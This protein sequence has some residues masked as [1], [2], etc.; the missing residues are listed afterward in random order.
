MRLFSVS[1]HPRLPAAKR[2]AALVCLAL[3]SA[4]V[5]A[6]PVITEFMASNK[7]ILTDEDGDYSDWIE[8]YN[9]DVAAV[10]L[11]NWSLTDSAQKKTKWQ[12]PAITIPAGGYL[13]VFASSKDRSDPAQPLHTNFSLSAD[14]E[15]LG[16]IEPDGTT[17]ATEFSPAFPS[18]END[19]SYGVTQPL[20]PSESPQTGSFSVPTPGARNGNASTLA[21]L[22]T[23]S[24]STPSGFFSGTLTL[25]VSGQ[26]AG[27]KIRYVLAPPS[28]AG[29]EV[30]EPTAESPEYTG[31]IALSSSTLVRA[32]VFS[33]DDT[34]RGPAVSAHY[35]QLSGTGSERVD[36]FSSRLPLIVIDNHGYGAMVKDGIDRPGWIYGFAPSPDGMASF[37]ETSDFAFPI[38]FAVRG[39]SSSGFP[40]KSFKLKTL[41]ALGAKQPLAPFGLPAFNKWQLIG[42]WGFD[43]AFI[44]NAYVYALSNRIG[45]WAA[46]TKLVEVFF[47]NNDDGLNASDYAGIYTLTD[48]I[49]VDPQRVNIADISPSDVTAPGVTGGYILKIDWPDPG[50]Y[51]WTT[52][53]AVTLILDTPDADDLTSAQTNYI[54]EYVQ[55]MENAIYAD[56]ASGWSSRHYLD[57]LDRDSWIDFHLLNVFAK[58]PDA[59]IASTYLTKD[60]NG[61]LMA[62]PV[63]DFDRASGSA[64]SRSLPWD[65]WHDSD[66]QDPWD[67]GW[68]G[69][70]AHDPDFMQAWV[71]RWQSLRTTTFS[72]QNLAA[73]A[74]DLAAQIGPEAA[75]RDSAQY[76]DDASQYPGGYAG[77]I[78]HFKD[79]MTHRA[80]WIDQQ[81][82]PA[83]IVTNHDGRLQIAPP[84]GSQVAYTLDGTDPRASGGDLA[85]GAQLADPPFE[86]ADA[87]G[88]RIRS[89]SAGVTAF[90]GSPWS[91]MVDAHDKA[92]S[93]STSRLVNLSAR[94]PL[95]AGE[96][97][98]IAGVVVK[99]AEGKTFL[100]RAVGPGL[101]TMDLNRPLADPVLRIV[102]QDGTEIARNEGWEDG[103]DA[104]RLPEIAA[105]V[106]AFPLAPGSRDA[107]LLVH[108]PAGLYSL[109]VSSASDQTGVALAEIYE[110]DHDGR[111]VNFSA[112][113]PV[114]NGN[115]LLIGGL[116]IDGTAPR[117]V[118]VRAVGPTLST[119]GVAQPLADPVLTLYAGANIVTS[120]DDWGAV[121]PTAI[122][123]AAAAVG[124]FALPDGS[125]DSALL[126]TLDPGIYTI[127]IQS[128][129]E[130]HGVA[131]A[132]VYEVP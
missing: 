81:F 122:A 64:D 60:R 116:V 27:Q 69:Q 47:N 93:A 45:R 79:W 62:G 123:S 22:E 97:I 126:V 72:D 31:P 51:I 132:E 101:A 17:V 32:A 88:L 50:D 67:Y 84:P 55:S 70:L 46:R 37:S 40:K 76:P 117:T 125:K 14:G 114:R 78:A 53:H 2:I 39:R 24:F 96:N 12:F 41:N 120:N 87:A 44:R 23:V 98:L 7:T 119:A 75:S 10:N 127:L 61:K 131:L 42:P 54:K 86:I 83:P 38:E 90:P 106:G 66:D 16:L 109:Q 9:P 34:R 28:P 95:S 1:A 110:T 68:W 19:I 124:A 43:R 85:A 11:Q 74:D 113:G 8:I 89:Y 102:R 21:I 3:G 115:G 130:D 112:R 80:Q 77:E 35:V 15:Y 33:S 94:G 65:E 56:S 100:A 48:K 92:Q 104:D 30:P 13:V 36:A 18:Q 58:N 105:T 103:P 5:S 20:D 57:Y 49:E 128:K 71:D 121:N 107:A 4:N 73:L 82:L 91:R 25:T 59:F 6:H 129:G 63:W 118:L 52:D 108:L 29:A 111:A 26:S 99:Q